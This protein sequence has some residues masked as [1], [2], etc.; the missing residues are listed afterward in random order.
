[1]RVP[2]I[3]REDVRSKKWWARRQER[4]CP[5]Y[6]L[7]LFRF[8]P[9]RSSLEQQI[10]TQRNRQNAFNEY[11]EKHNDIVDDLHGRESSVNFDLQKWNSNDA[12]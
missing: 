3:Q 8:P 9:L 5:P 10:I 11:H 12:Q 1:M 4:I 7:T 6:G 2:T